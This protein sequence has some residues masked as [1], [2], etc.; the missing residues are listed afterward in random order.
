MCMKLN[1]TVV[2]PPYARQ[3]G[4]PTTKD[5]LVPTI[6]AVY[7]NIGPANMLSLGHYPK[8]GVG[9]IYETE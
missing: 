4:F 6:T 3:V 7:E 1:K 8:M 9:V 5:G 2:T